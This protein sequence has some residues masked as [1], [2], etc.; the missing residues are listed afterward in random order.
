MAEKLTKPQ[1]DMLRRI[2]QSSTPLSVWPDHR[3]LRK[4]LAIG[5][6][7]AVRMGRYEAT[8]AGLEANRG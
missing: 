6:V 4:L 2:C 3:T 1:R 5:L 7:Q 8:V